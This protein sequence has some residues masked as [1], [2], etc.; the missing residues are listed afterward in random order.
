MS[1]ETLDGPY[2]EWLYGQVGAVDLRSSDH[3]YWGLFKLLYTKEFVWIVPN[4]DNRAEDGRSLR[5][6]FSQELNLGGLDPDWLALSCSFLELL[7]GLSRRIAF[8]MEDSPRLWFWH[9]IDTLE[10][11]DFTDAEEVPVNTVDDILDR[12]IWRQYEPNG[13]GGLFPLQN[14]TKDQREV[15]LWYQLNAYLIERF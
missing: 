5:L 2:L 6:E 3:T 7:V 11:G 14:P 15:E 4:D 12:V 8:E 13:E 9:L 10:L 1:D